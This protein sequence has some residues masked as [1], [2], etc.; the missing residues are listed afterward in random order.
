ALTWIHRSK[1]KRARSSADLLCR[2][3][4]HS[5]QFRFA[6]RT[7]IVCVANDSLA[8]GQ[9]PAER[10]IQDLLK[11]IEQLATLVQKEAAV[12]ALDRHQTP[13]IRVANCRPEVKACTQ[14]H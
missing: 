9:R 13:R 4:R 10:L 5:A 8:L 7:I 11:R 12:R 3:L 14:Q 6:S 1:N 2:V